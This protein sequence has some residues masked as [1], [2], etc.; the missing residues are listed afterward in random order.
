TATDSPS[1]SEPGRVSVYQTTAPGASNCLNLV[2]P[3][4]TLSV[5]QYATAVAAAQL[6]GDAGPDLVVSDD[7][8][9]LLAIFKNTSTVGGSISF[10]SPLPSQSVTLA[11]GFTPV[12]VVALDVDQDG[13]SDLAVIDGNQGA[14]AK[15]HILRNNG[16][17][18]LQEQVTDFPV[19]V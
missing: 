5:G 12:Y 7:V 16:A 1:D 6:L 17:G 18:N 11:G 2:S 15:V 10:E 13:D 4:P 3:S 8:E 19:G 9:H 14:P